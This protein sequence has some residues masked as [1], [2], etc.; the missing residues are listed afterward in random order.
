MSSV[1]KVILIGRL[2]KEPE[3]RW[4]PS[5][6]AVTNISIATD[7][8]WTDKGTGE[9]KEEVEWHRV[10]FFGKLAEVAGEHL[11]K[12]SQVYIEGRLK[13]NK[14][15]DKETGTDRYSTDVIAER[16]Q[17]LGSKPKE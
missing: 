9:A 2:G 11:K 12:G 15:K 6:E 17:M 5:G 13:T 14:W 10:T 8:K 16:M 4:M 3:T 7:S 1:N